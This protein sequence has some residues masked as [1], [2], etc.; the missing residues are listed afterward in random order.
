MKKLR[1]T[2]NKAILG[3]KPIIKGTRI[4]VSS[5]LDLLA[6]GL[7]Q[8]EILK[9]YPILTK[10]HIQ[11]AVS[12]ASERMKRESTYPVTHRGDSVVFSSV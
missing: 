7:D 3:G 6:S 9:E 4:A 2:V 5:I 8:N 1:I 10:K 11:D 12:Y